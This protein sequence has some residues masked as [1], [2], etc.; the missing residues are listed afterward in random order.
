MALGAALVAGAIAA[1]A[2]GSLSN[3]SAPGLGSAT[4]PSPP[5]S[6]FFAAALVVALSMVVAGAVRRRSG[7][8]AFVTVLLLLGG[9]GAAAS[10]PVTAEVAS[11]TQYVS[12]RDGTPQTIVQSRGQL[13]IDLHV[14]GEGR[15]PAPISVR[16]GEGSTTITVA[17]GVELDLYGHVG[18]T[19]TYWQRWTRGQ[20]GIVDFSEL[21]PDAEGVV[22]ARLSDPNAPV[23]TKQPVF[24]DQDSG[25]ISIQILPRPRIGWHDLRADSRR[26]RRP[27]GAPFARSDP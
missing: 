25:S 19:Q 21:A 3:G 13:S 26:L 10:P 6:G 1:L 4:R 16:K 23:V 24:L 17:S 2:M 12:N 20:A 8:L 9:A 18:T 15:T 27:V 11:W 5:R 14:L 22:D 7:F